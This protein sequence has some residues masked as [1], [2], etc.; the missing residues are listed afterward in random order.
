MTAPRRIS[1]LG[2][3]GSV[4]L[5]TLDLV[6]RAEPGTFEVVA[7]TARSNAAACA[8]HAPARM[9]ARSLRLLAGLVGARYSLGLCG[10]L[11][12]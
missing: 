1:V 10:W 4:G 11:D 3:T 6:A 12:A 8:S 2:A 7:L 9:S 5:A